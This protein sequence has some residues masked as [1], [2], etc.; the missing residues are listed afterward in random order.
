MWSAGDHGDGRTL[1][2]TRSSDEEER[3]IQLEYADRCI[4]S[5]LDIVA[6]GH[7][8]YCLDIATAVGV[9]ASKVAFRQRIEH[10]DEHQYNGIIEWLLMAGFPSSDLAK[11][12]RVFHKEMSSELFDSYIRGW[13]ITR[14]QT[15]TGPA[16]DSSYIHLAIF[17]Y[18]A[19][20]EVM[21]ALFDAGVTGSV[22]YYTRELFYWG[23]LSSVIGLLWYLTSI[24]SE[25]GKYLLY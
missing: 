12:I 24:S 6:V 15:S 19:S 1:T 18:P 3:T 16:T 21:S 25:G 10:S 22:A 23:G 11:S 7:E 8:L 9:A 20:W 14:S 5:G 2:C 13:S 4:S 17:L